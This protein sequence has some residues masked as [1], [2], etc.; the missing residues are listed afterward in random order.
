MTV[1]CAFCKRKHTMCLCSESTPQRN[2]N[3][4]SWNYQPKELQ[5]FYEMMARKVDQDTAKRIFDID[6]KLFGD[7]D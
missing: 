2:Q 5:Q 6:K 1:I 3:V 7:S 4:R